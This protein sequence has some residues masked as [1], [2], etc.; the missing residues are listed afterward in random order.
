[1]DGLKTKRKAI[2][3]HCLSR[4]RIL[5]RSL[6]LAASFS[7]G[8]ISNAI[9]ASAPV[10]IFAA[11][12]TAG[13]IEA[14]AKDF[15]GA[16][17]ETVRAV[18]AASSILA[19]QIMQGA[20]ADIYLAANAAWMDELERKDG[21]Q[22]GSRVDLL[23]NNLVLIAPLNQPLEI[24]VEPGFALAKILGQG[25]LAIGDPSHVPA[26]IYAKAAL[27]R[28]GIWDSLAAK[29]AF[30]NDVRAALVLVERGEAMAGIVYASDAMAGARV[31]I[32]A[33]FPE[34]LRAPIVYPMAI[35]RARAAPSVT[36]FHRHLQ[37]AAAGSIFREHGFIHPV[38]GS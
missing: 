21:V 34:E 30:A 37:S 2:A 7:F 14:V 19:R 23:G 22:P 38:A 5:K 1:M 31:R 3:S 18:F 10:T 20:P 27:E 36:A 17:G 9:A 16:T 26:G 6:G 32:V 28:L 24:S 12:S 8:G 25:R 11:A 4:R 33:E 15:E 35:V 13:A 29:L